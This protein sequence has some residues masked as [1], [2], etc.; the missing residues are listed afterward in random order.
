MRFQDN[1]LPIYIRHLRRIGVVQA[2][3]AALMHESAI[4][5]AGVCNNPFPFGVDFLVRKR[6][7]VFARR[8]LR[9]FVE[10]VRL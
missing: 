9:R 8:R 7:L 6:S 1:V 5:A 2:N 4:L 10:Y 3:R